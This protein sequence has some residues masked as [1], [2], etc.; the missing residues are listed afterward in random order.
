MSTMEKEFKNSLGESDLGLDWTLPSYILKA[1][2]S[3]MF[4]ES[5]EI[6]AIRP[7][8]IDKRRV[9]HNCKGTEFERGGHQPDIMATGDRWFE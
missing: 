5:I 6:Q 2:R 7:Y 4:Q 8:Q 3:K 9:A 1:Q